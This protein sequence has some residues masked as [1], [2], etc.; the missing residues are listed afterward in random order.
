MKNEPVCPSCGAEVPKGGLCGC[1]KQWSYWELRYHQR[2][3]SVDF[4]KYQIGLGPKP[5]DGR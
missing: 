1:G 2:L 4:R 3:D 5:E